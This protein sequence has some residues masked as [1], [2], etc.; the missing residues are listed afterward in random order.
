M[1]KIFIT[2]LKIAFISIGFSACE[3]SE[4]PSNTQRLSVFIDRTGNPIQPSS[5][6]LF[7]H[8]DTS[9][10]F[11]GFSLSLMNVTDNPYNKS[12]RFEIPATS[13]GLLSNED[14]R[15][16]R[17]KV[18][19]HKVS[20]CLILSNRQNYNYQQSVIFEVVV[21]ELARLSKYKDGGVLVLYSDLQEHNSEFN[22]YRRLNKL[23][24]EKRFKNELSALELTNIK[25]YIT[26]QPDTP[27]QSKQFSNMLQLYQS[28][29]EPKGLKI[30]VG[31]T[32]TQLF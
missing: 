1:K 25:L 6:Q 3:S 2:L 4:Q 17:I 14:E 5:E 18:F 30:Y 8:L 24:L 23:S 27:S 32:N 13:A 7:N 10:V 20:E 28:I 26:Y 15:R 11:D 29:L 16:R 9:R 21:K 19:K 22:S 12:E 31:D